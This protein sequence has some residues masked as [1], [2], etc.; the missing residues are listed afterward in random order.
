MDR[1]VS[2]LGEEFLVKWKGYDES[3]NSWQL[4]SDIDAPQLLREFRLRSLKAAR[5]ELSIVQ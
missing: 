1:Q 2:E 3:S 5:T 4:K